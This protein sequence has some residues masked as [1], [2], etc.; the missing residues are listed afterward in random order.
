MIEI[1]GCARK[2][3][4]DGYDSIAPTESAQSAAAWS[5]RRDCRTS[6]AH[7]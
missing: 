5:L 7:S 3:R 1:T 4:R 2:A 6:F